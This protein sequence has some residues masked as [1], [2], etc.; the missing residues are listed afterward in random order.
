MGSSAARTLAEGALLGATNAT[1]SHPPTRPTLWGRVDA[2][3]L[4][5]LSGRAD[6]PALYVVAFSA[7]RTV[8]SEPLTGPS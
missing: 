5:P 7:S 3:M 8:S 6:G 4:R 2:L 1:R